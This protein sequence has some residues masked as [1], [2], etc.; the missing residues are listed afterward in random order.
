MLI[1]IGYV[2]VSRVII[3][4]RIVIELLGGRLVFS[5][6]L[7]TLLLLSVGLGLLLRLTL[8]AT[9]WTLVNLVEFGS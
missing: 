5:K 6:L 1:I 4:S 2:H 8:C 3:T 9:L 7:S